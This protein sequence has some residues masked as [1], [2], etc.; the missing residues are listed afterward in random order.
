MHL[1]SSMTEK[2]MFDLETMGTTSTPC[3]V[4]QCSMCQGDTEYFC[5][6]CPCDLCPQC[7]ENHVKDLNTI[8]HDVVTYSEKLNS[9][10]KEE[11]CVRH[12]CMLIGMY[13][14][15]C[16][17]P[18]CFNCTQHKGHR[19]L[20]IR[21]EYRTMQQQH[22]GTFY[23]IRSDALFYR[24]VL[25]TKIKAEF[26]TCYTELSIFQSQMITKAQKLKNLLDDV[27][28]DF[29]YNV[30]CDFD[31]K[32]RCLKQK[33]KMITQI[34]NQQRYV[35]TYEQSSVIPIQF[36]S[37]IKTTHL[38]QMRLTLHTSN[39]S[40]T[41]SFNKEDV[42]ESLSAIEIAERGNRRVENK[43]LLKLLPAP[44]FCMSLTMTD[45]DLCYHISRVTSDQVWAS[46][47]DGN[48]FL[49]NT[50]GDTLYFINACTY[51]YGF[52]TLNNDN[53][54]IYT[55][56]NNTIY[57]LSKEM[58]TATFIKRADSIWKPQ[59]VYCSPRTSDLMVGMYRET[60]GSTEYISITPNTHAYF[61]LQTPFTPYKIGKVTRYNQSGQLTQNIQ[62]DNTGRG[63]YRHPNFITENNN[64]DVVVSDSCAVIVTNREGVHRFFYRGHP[65][66]SGL[67]PWGICTDAL[68]HILVCDSGSC[69]VQ[70][71]DKDGQ[72]LS[73]L[74]IRPSGL[75][76]PLSLSYDVKTHRLWVAARNKVVVYRYIDRQHARTDLNPATADVMESLSEIPNIGTEK[77]QQGNQCLL[78]LMSPPELLHSLTVTGADRCYHISCVT[79]DRFWVSDN[80]DNL[81]LTNT[82]GDT[83]HNLN[84]LYS[85]LR[86]DANREV[87]VGLHT[88]RGVDRSH[89]LSG[90]TSRRVR[91]DDN[92][93][94]LTLTNTRDDS[95]LYM[96]DLC[97]SLH[98]ESY[99][100]LLVG[101]LTVNSESELIYI[102]RNH[103]INKLSKDMK[104]TCTFI[105]K[106]DATW[107]PRCVYCSPST[108]DLLVGMY[109]ESIGPSKLTRHNQNG[110]L[111]QTIKHD[112]M[113]LDLYSKTDFI[114]ENNNGDIVVSDESAVVVTER[115]GRHRFSYTGHPSGSGL[116]PHG[117]CTDPMSHILVC[118]DR[119]NTIQLLDKDGQFLSHLLKES[120]ILES[121]QSLSYDVNTH[122]LWVGSEKDNKVC[123]YRYIDQHGHIKDED[124]Y[125]H[126]MCAISN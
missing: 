80:R 119:T 89:H 125:R 65:S 24:P 73:H 2:R 84:D 111:T 98:S 62:H 3:R 82:R 109:R 33:I 124:T 71:I 46:D 54:L 15:P 83:L 23:T 18:V 99:R 91:V 47:A 1:I 34:G 16:E 113:G 55:D 8:D 69:T 116:W 29:M 117:I 31:V 112:N 122:S 7:K 42:M 105:E 52:H 10:K 4:H 68:A 53:E 94:N 76:C 5:V 126:D 120:K 88:E 49:I 45:V 79:S 86:R 74:L 118:D 115:G 20:D 25:L 85:S 81:I 50:A 22:E 56:K 32:H 12:P 101:I 72:F 67:D 36:L 63:L 93:D 17:L 114:T 97:S 59:C 75:F 70:M 107:S 123:V 35:H 100:K 104:T 37:S 9:N 78:K 26:K 43:S 77:P 66:G 95:L 44:E 27:K 87:S 108:G 21:K 102:D 11:C 64:G 92:K 41:E 14:E 39:L 6:S 103:N 28:Y 96:N 60:R 57:K 30:F 58:K 38:R 19:L 106:T 13:C 61:I 121:P 48:L 110:Q 90:M 40:M 51:L